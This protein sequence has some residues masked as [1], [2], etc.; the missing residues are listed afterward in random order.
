MVAGGPHQRSVLGPSPAG[1]IT[2]LQCLNFETLATC[3]GGSC[4]CYHRYRVA[5]FNFQA[6]NLINLHVIT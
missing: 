4:I 3:R 2:V 1:L 6:L 5:Q